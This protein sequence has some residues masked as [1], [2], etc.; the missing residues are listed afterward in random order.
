MYRCGCK[1]HR[2]RTGGSPEI[3][4]I[5]M[6]NVCIGF[7]C[8]VEIPSK[9]STTW[10]CISMFHLH[11]MLCLYTHLAA[12]TLYVVQRFNGIQSFK[13]LLSVRRSK[14]DFDRRHQSPGARTAWQSRGDRRLGPV[15]RRTGARMSCLASWYPSFVHGVGTTAEKLYL[16]RHKRMAL[17]LL[18]SLT[19]LPSVSWPSQR[20]GLPQFRQI[21][22]LE[23]KDVV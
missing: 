2:L 5:S 4:T 18:R 21:D 9:R 11:K 3:N 7:S 13:Q 19:H 20:L 12:Y 23:G 6:I 14:R 15:R 1:E 8:L 10:C 22:W 16:H 17:Y